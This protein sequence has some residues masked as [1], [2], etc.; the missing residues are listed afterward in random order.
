MLI[1]WAGWFVQRTR[2]G[3]VQ[4]A[5]S[6]CASAFWRRLRSF[7]FK[8]LF[9]EYDGRTIV[10]LA[11]CVVVLFVSGALMSA[12]QLDYALML[13]IHRIVPIVLAFGLGLALFFIKPG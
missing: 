4:V 1:I 6:D 11:L 9:D 12:G 5:L 3:W 13:T 2:C 7:L 8:R 10:F